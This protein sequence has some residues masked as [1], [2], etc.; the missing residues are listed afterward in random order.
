MPHV[1]VHPLGS[2]CLS[3]TTYITLVFYL[4]VFNGPLSYFSGRWWTSLKGTSLRSRWSPSNS[5]LIMSPTWSVLVLDWVNTSLTS[6]LWRTP[7]ETSSPCVS[8]STWWALDYF[9]NSGWFSFLFFTQ[10][11]F[12]FLFGLQTR[13]NCYPVVWLKPDFDC[14]YC[15]FSVCKRLNIKVQFHGNTGLFFGWNPPVPFYEQ[16]SFQLPW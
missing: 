6:W 2:L 7:R 4:S 8:S 11:D 3:P 16:L 12:S 10:F 13:Q 5:S 14:R 15:P 1:Y 9:T